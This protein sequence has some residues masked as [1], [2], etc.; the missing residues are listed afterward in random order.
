[1]YTVLFAGNTA[2]ESLAP[3]VVYQGKNMYESW[4]FDG[5]ENC[6]FACTESGWMSDTVL[7]DWFCAYFVS[8]VSSK[9]VFLFFDGHGS[10]LIDLYQMK[11]EIGAVLWHSSENSEE[12][13][14][15]RFCLQNKRYKCRG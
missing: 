4:T 3:L 10:H 1:M 9:T 2:G 11:K 8:A 13:S 12:A 14:R 5:P 6:Q 15:H 7:E